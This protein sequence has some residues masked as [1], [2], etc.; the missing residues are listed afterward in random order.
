MFAH[1]TEKS[2]ISLNTNS[3]NAWEV[4]VEL[5]FVSDHA[6]E[7]KDTDDHNSAIL[8]HRAKISSASHPSSEEYTTP[9]YSHAINPPIP[10]H[11]FEIGSETVL[12]YHPPQ[13]YPSGDSNEYDI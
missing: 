12:T 11:G 13:T 7:S 4:Y 1:G 10:I 5:D 2:W 3:S 9:T 8:S 6:S